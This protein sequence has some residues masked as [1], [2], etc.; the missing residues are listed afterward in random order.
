MIFMKVSII[1]RLIGLILNI[2]NEIICVLKVI[3]DYYLDINWILIGIYVVVLS[4]FF[5][6]FFFRCCCVL[7]VN[8]GF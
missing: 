1:D 8:V 6:V 7:L 2:F 5:V 3:F 4:V